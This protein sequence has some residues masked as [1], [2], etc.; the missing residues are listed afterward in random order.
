[1]SRK[2]WINDEIAWLLIWEFGNVVGY[3]YVLLLLLL[4]YY[5]KWFWS[6]YTKMSF[7]WKWENKWLIC[8]VVDMIG[9]VIGYANLIM[10]TCLIVKS[11]S[12]WC[13]THEIEYGC[14]YVDEKLYWKLHAMCLC[15]CL[16]NCFT[17]FQFCPRI[18]NKNCDF[19][20]RNW[21]SV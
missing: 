3:D 17:R 11:M 21:L 2:W 6:F 4:M 1:M 19:L 8:V 7:M 5:H 9:Y 18:W 12:M 10:G 14:D 20:V 13:W 16:I 15:L